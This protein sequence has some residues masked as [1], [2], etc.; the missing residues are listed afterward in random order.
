MTEPHSTQDAASRPRHRTCPPWCNVR[1]GVS[2]G[3]EDWVHISEPLVVADEVAA[4][5]CMSVD[6]DTE[7]EDGPYVVVGSREYS[8]TEA[9]RL[10]ASLIELA[11]LGGSTTP[12]EAA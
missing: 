9:E 5:L 7:A 10:G 8:L 11:S 6:P 12:P 3:E 4:R 2:E 1:H